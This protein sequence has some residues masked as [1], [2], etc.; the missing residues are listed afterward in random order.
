MRRSTRSTRLAPPA[1]V[2]VRAPG[3]GLAH[4]APAPP[5]APH[6]AV[7]ERVHQDHPDPALGEPGLGGK[8]LRAHVAQGTTLEQRDRD[9][10]GG[11]VDLQR[12]RRLGQAPEAEASVAARVVAMVELG[13]VAVRDPLRQSAAVLLGASGLRDELVPVVR[14]RGQDP[15]V[16]HDEGDAGRMQPVLQQLQRPAQLPRRAVKLALCG[17]SRASRPGRG[18]RPRRTGPPTRPC[19]RPRRRLPSRRT[20]S[21]R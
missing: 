3:R 17:D 1:R 18:W 16:A 2:L 8:V 9:P 15:P 20:R 11:G 14:I 4:L 13:G 5:V 10:D 6:P 12:V 21:S 19:R 7:V